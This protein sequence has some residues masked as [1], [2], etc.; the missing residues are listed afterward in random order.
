MS[1]TELRDRLGAAANCL[2]LVADIVAEWA[3][4]SYPH[5]MPPTDAMVG[6]AEMAQDMA[7]RCKAAARA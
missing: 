1:E 6:L 7:D 4:P 3:S 2:A 5:E